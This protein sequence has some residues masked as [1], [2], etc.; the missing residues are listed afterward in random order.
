MLRSRRASELLDSVGTSCIPGGSL[1]RL[2][3]QG[4]TALGKGV[5]LYS[6]YAAAYSE[7]GAEGSSSVVR[8]HNISCGAAT[9]ALRSVKSGADVSIFRSPGRLALHRPKFLTTNRAYRGFEQG[10][11]GG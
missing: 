7:T 1:P 11:C 10:Y 5:W 3:R 9:A 2:V 8:A 6:S 4:A